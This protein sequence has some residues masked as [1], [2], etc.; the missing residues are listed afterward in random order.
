MLLS[1][2]STNQSADYSLTE[3]KP[4]CLIRVQ[5]NKRCGIFSRISYSFYADFYSLNRFM[6]FDI[7]SEM[8]P[9]FS[10]EIREFFA[11]CAVS[12]VASVIA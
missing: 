3:K 1:E 7:A 4:V 11:A 2:P 10:D 6:F 5:N 12:R 8:S 9:T